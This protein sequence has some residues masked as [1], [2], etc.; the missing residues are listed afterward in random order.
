VDFILQGKI[1]QGRHTDNPARH[2]SVWT[3]QR[4]TSIIRQ[5]L[6][7]IPFLLQPSQ[8][9]LPWDRHQICWL[10]YLVACLF[11]LTIS[12]VAVDWQEPVVLQY[13]CGHPLPTLTDIGPAVAAN[14]H[15]TIPINHTGPSPRKQSPDVTTPSEMAEPD[16][17]LLLI[18]QKDERLS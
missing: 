16:Y 18:W 14:K 13:K 11:K 10:A 15:I 17:C 9:V 7:W 3:N 6:H 1:T 4:P 2:H 5:F 12:E 8:F